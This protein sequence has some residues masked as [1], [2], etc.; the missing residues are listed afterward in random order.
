[1]EQHITVVGVL[2]IIFGALSALLGLAL[3]GIITGAGV[4]S[5]DQEAAFITGAVG[6]I[7]GGALILISL[8]SIIGG[9][10]LLKRKNWARI[11]II[12]VAALS[13]LNF[14]FGTA[15]GVYAIWVLINDQTRP[16]FT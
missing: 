15:Y 2:S 6:T 14:P 7:V 9:V 11:V 3:F 8:P 16:F 4:L 12:I 5:G 13:L 1:M 10:G